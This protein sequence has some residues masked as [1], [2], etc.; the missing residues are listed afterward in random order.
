MKN[1]TVKLGLKNLFSIIG[2]TLLLVIIVSI[3]VFGKYLFS[4]AGYDKAETAITDDGIRIVTDEGT[5]SAGTNWELVLYG[6][7]AAELTDESS[8][9]EGFFT[10]THSRHV[11]EL[12]AKSA[13]T[14]Y[15]VVI[16]TV[17][18]GNFSNAEIYKLT[19]DENLKMT[20]EHRSTDGMP[21]FVKSGE[22][23]LVQDGKEIKLS[24]A[25]TDMLAVPMCGSYTDDKAE[26]NDSLTFIRYSTFCYYFDLEKGMAYKFENDNDEGRS[27]KIDEEL[28]PFYKDMIDSFK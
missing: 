28:L 18:G 20:Y 21:F 15:A 14:A 17:G 6:D 27:L 5:D 16:T 8:V 4:G 9:S 23:F 26:R 7:D 11:F 24:D 19:V 2:I 3:A 25:Q 1:D 12:K 22:S 13:G 10:A